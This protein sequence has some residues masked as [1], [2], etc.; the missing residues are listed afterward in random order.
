MKRT[1]YLV[2]AFFG[3]VI[4]YVFFARFLASADTTMGAF[5]AQLFAT[6]A[7]SGFTTD[8][9]ITSLVFWFWSHGEARTHGMR[10]WWAYVAVNLVVGLSCA[11]PA[12]LYF[13]AGRVGAS[14]HRG[15]AT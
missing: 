4:P 5:V 9:L 14:P 7:A 2:L 8:L 3:A 6:P 1:V 12:F 10:N 13:R 11:L 15:S